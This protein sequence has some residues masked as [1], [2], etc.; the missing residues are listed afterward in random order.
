[1]PVCLPCPG[2]TLDLGPPAWVGLCWTPDSA[3]FRSRL[4]SCIIKQ[5]FII[6]ETWTFDSISYK[7]IHN[8]ASTPVNKQQV[9]TKVQFF[10]VDSGIW[11]H[12]EQW[13]T[14]YWLNLISVPALFDDWL[15][16]IIYI[17]L[18]I[19]FITRKLIGYLVGFEGRGWL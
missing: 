2:L 7:K 4:P 14:R 12:I 3:A 5:H 15:R 9:G 6:F 19:W 10:R 11:Q 8:S 18:F 13:L 17:Q 16:Y 1:M